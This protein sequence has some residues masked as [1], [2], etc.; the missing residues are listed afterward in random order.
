MTATE[1]VAGA[2]EGLPLVTITTPT[3]NPGAMLAEAVA[4]VD[5]Q[6]Y[7]NIEHVIVDGGSTDDHLAGLEALKG[8]KRQV[9]LGRDESM[10]AAINE[11]IARSQGS[12]LFNLNADDLLFP[13]AVARAVE[14]LLRHPDVDIAYGDHL[15][16]LV[17][18]ES[19]DVN[20]IPA[21]GADRWGQVLVYLSQPSVFI[22]RRT[23]DRIGPFAERWRGVG[24]F[25][26][27]W[28]AF[29]SGVHFG[30]YNGIGSIV[31]LHEA[32]LSRSSTWWR[33]FDELKLETVPPS[34]EAT[35]AERYRLV[36][37]KVVL[38]RLTVPFHL[39][40]LP[41][42]YATLHWCRYYRA[43]ITRRPAP[44]PVLSLRLPFLSFD[45]RR[46]LQLTPT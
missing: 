3:L 16:L 34:V 1:P 25:E 6:T 5:H 20:Y 21:P 15:T 36:R 7:R 26:Y 17:P 4:S 2:V 41:R 39:R 12:I 23:F 32:N 19:F 45:A 10:Y 18:E 13:D 27:W 9:V 30:K 44:R 11:G 14:F 28:R 22:R 37:R 29:R 33:E 40:G 31:R 8:P 42:R 35:R 38:N 24:D 46:A 43:V